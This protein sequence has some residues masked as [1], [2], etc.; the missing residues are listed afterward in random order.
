MEEPLRVLSK[1]MKNFQKLV[2]MGIG[3]ELRRDDALGVILVRK[4]KKELAKRT[5]KTQK[6]VLIECGSVP[7]NFLGYLEKEKPTHVIIV[8]AIDMNLDPGSIAILNANAIPSYP[9]ISTHK[10]SPHILLK[11]IE[12]VVGA[13]VIV[14]GVQPEDLS[15]GEGLTP[16]VQSSIEMLSRLLA[17][18]I[19]G[20]ENVS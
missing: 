20:R 10:V 5:E 17:K 19:E 13:R 16:K 15:F 9:T 3:N 8:D 1:F 12:E 14:I 2:I 6:I 4:L 18:I 11:Y 7:E